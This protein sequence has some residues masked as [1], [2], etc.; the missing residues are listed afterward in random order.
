MNMTERGSVSKGGAPVA[1]EGFQRLR[2]ERDVAVRTVRALA[3]IVLAQAEAITA[4]APPAVLRLIETFVRQGFA[5]TREHYPDVAGR[6]ARAAHRLRG[7]RREQGAAAPHRSRPPDQ[8][9][10]AGRDG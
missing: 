1:M 10:S 4:D 6:F 3:A 8:S 9:V 7:V 2:A 5:V